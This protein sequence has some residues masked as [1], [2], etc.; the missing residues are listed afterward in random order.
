M[1]PSIFILFMT[2][3][4]QNNTS[5]AGYCSPPAGPDFFPVQELFQSHSHQQ[6]V[7]LMSSLTYCFWI[8]FY[9]HTHLNQ[10]HQTSS[11]CSRPSTPCSSATISQRRWSWVTWFLQQLP[12]PE[13]NAIGIIPKPNQPENFR[14]IVDLSAPQVNDHT[15]I[16]NCEVCKLV[17]DCDGRMTLK[18]NCC[19]KAWFTIFWL[20]CKN[21]RKT[22]ISVTQ[23]V[24]PHI[25]I[26][27]IWTFSRNTIQTKIL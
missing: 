22:S 10:L 9:F 19:P 14:L 27:F 25:K 23:C 13:K 17:H 5:S 21:R 24:V 8:G 20:Q 26:I 16:G 2:T 11:R 12:R 6:F 3:I 1:P 18:Q 4:G 7:A 15:R